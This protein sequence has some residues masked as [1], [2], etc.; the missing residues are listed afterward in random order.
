MD[1]AKQTFLRSMI[2]AFSGFM[3]LALTLTAQAAE[4]MSVE[5]A[6]N[7]SKAGKIYLIDIR[8]PDEW[9]QT[10]IPAS[11]APISMHVS[12]FLDKL[13][14]LTG[15]EKDAK[16]ALICAHGNR[17]TY[18]SNELE[19]R[20]FTSII[21]VAEGMLGSGKGAGWLAAK[22]PVISAP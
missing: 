11:A 14:K 6:S 9:K 21:N 22:L 15:G 2:G 4:F 17:S 18:I 13:A 10:G 1:N 16:I 3:I 8:H 5:K 12:G 20:G 19:K 7:L